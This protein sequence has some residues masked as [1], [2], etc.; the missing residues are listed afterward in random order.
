VL[1]G[2]MSDDK[3]IWVA[4]FLHYPINI[5]HI[6]KEIISTD[7][8]NRLHNILQNSTAYLTYPSN[9]TSRFSHSLGCMHL[10]GEIFR[11]SI[12]NATNTDRVFFFNQMKEEIMKIIDNEEFRNE[13]RRISQTGNGE[14]KSPQDYKKELGSKLVDPLYVA[15]LP[16]RCCD[17]FENIFVILFQAIRLA[18]LLHDL[19]H[20]PFSHVTEFAIKELIN[21]IQSK[22]EN[23]IKITPREEYLMKLMDYAQGKMEFHESLSVELSKRILELVV[24]GYKDKS[25]TF[26]DFM[27]VKY[28][29]LAIAHDD[30][31][32]GA[33]HAIIAGDIDS[34]RLDYIS[35]DL[36]MSGLEVQPLQYDR[37]ISSFQLIYQ[38]IDNNQSGEPLFL[39]SVRA[40]STIEDF[41]RLRF[42]LYKYVIYHHRV[43]KTDALLKNIILRLSR[44]YLLSD[45]DINPSDLLRSSLLPDDIS[46]L[47]VILDP[48]KTFWKEQLA[49]Q[50]IQW[51]DSWLLSILRRAYFIMKSKRDE[52]TP[53]D[54]TEIQLEELISNHKKYYSLFKRADSF[55][56]VDA[57]FIQ[58]IP[59]DFNWNEVRSIFKLQ[60]KPE[61]LFKEIDSYF[62]DIKL[63]HEGKI[64]ITSV[65]TS[66]GFLIS[67]LIHLLFL[68]GKKSKRYEFIENA[69]PVIKA[70]FSIDDI[71]FMPKTITAGANNQL[72]IVSDTKR[73][74]KIGDV[75]RIINDLERSSRL[76]PP[77]YIYIYSNTINPNILS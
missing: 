63:I 34:D 15:S 40:L 61:H 18:A 60:E 41:F 76:S 2:I 75:S 66:K 24:E 54:I 1:G 30:G 46:G 64:T 31:I 25:Q 13:F 4:D 55:D 32:F 8:F 67:S 70:T 35:R 65:R 9:R 74:M 58:S 22:S 69:L 23:G 43:V 73:I 51:D 3:R 17:K 59:S 44:E 10:A 72:N 42:K 28:I 14:K 52:L 56:E 62:E 39:P 21:E 47:W 20:P 53:P 6:E 37:L 19:G 33:L 12:I 26:Y 68:V 45:E 29:T 48:D 49:S 36:S 57:D 50:Y 5:S 11:Q 27:V 77:F 71:I 7:I 16:G 38:K